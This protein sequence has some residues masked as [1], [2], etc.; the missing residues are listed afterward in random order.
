[1]MQAAKPIPLTPL[2]EAYH[3]VASCM[4]FEVREMEWMTE[5]IADQQLLIPNQQRRQYVDDF[6][7]LCDS[8]TFATRLNISTVVFDFCHHSGDGR[9]LRRTPP[10]QSVPSLIFGDLESYFH[11]A[12]DRV[13]TV[14][15]QIKKELKCFW[16][17]QMQSWHPAGAS[18]IMPLDVLALIG[19][20]YSEGI[21]P[22]MAKQRLLRKPTQPTLS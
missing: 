19:A 11:P 18:G 17:A 13:H 21:T 16:L 20:F 9:K 15:M 1:M 8:V 6:L 7:R 4:D 10:D 22:R 14:Q 3:A 12:I 5:G 2:R